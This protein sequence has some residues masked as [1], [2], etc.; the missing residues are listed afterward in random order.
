MNYEGGF[1]INTVIGMQKRGELPGAP[2]IGWGPY[3]WA[4]GAEPNASGIAWLPADFNSDMVHPSTSGRTKVAE[5]LHAHFMQ[6]EWYR[7]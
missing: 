5:A 6:F 1:A 4:D 7:R 3:L 2:W